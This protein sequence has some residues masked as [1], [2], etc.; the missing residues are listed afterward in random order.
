MNLLLDPFSK[1]MNIYKYTTDEYGEIK[2]TERIYNIEK[3]KKHLL[4]NK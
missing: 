3:L 1:E 2:N 4:K